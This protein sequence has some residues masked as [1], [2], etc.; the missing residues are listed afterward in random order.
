LD[1]RTL[2]HGPP[3]E[4]NEFD[5][6]VFKLRTYLISTFDPFTPSTYLLYSEARINDFVREAKLLAEVSMKSP[7]IVQVFDF[8]FISSE[9][10]EAPKIPYIVMELMDGTL[11]ESHRKL[12]DSPED[13]AR[14]IITLGKAL[15]AAHVCKSGPLIH[16]DI[17]PNNI[18]YK[19]DESGDLQIKLGDFGLVLSTDLPAPE[20]YN[21]NGVLEYMSPERLMGKPGDVRSDIYSLG[22]VFYVLLTGR[23]PFEAESNSV[24]RIDNIQKGNFPPP[25]TVNPKLNQYLPLQ[26]I[27]QKAM[28]SNPNERYDNAAQLVG[29]LEKALQNAS[30]SSEKRFGHDKDVK[31]LK[32][33][34]PSWMS[35]FIIGTFLFVIVSLS[36]RGYLLI[37]AEFKEG[38]KQTIIA[39]EVNQHK[40]VSSRSPTGLESMMLPK[41]ERPTSMVVAADQQEADIE[42]VETPIIQEAI[43]QNRNS[44]LEK[45]EPKVD[46][47]IV[48][49]KQILE[50]MRGDMADIKTQIPQ[51]TETRPEAMISPVTQENTFQTKRE[52]LRVSSEDVSKPIVDQA[53]KPKLPER[54]VRKEMGSN[55]FIGFALQGLLGGSVP[56]NS[57]PMLLGFLETSNPYSQKS[58]LLSILKIL[59]TETPPPNDI[60]LAWPHII[61]IYEN[62]SPELKDLAKQCLV[63]ID[64]KYELTESQ[65]QQ[66]KK[67][68]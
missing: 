21:L 41:E 53:P 20:D 14:A 66:L 28:A 15:H 25:A 56:D 59:Q 36:R 8:G 17:K 45:E 33:N 4:S 5:P 34:L 60:A 11:A 19:D 43:Q 18:F 2:E 49:M 68:R 30:S 63:V 10:S 6:G 22:I 12:F 39:E 37:Q 64:Q 24:R 44:V 13:V 31:Q 7:H 35:L 52:T 42:V 54:G 1:C 50:Q 29:D 26:R 51:K 16:R 58:G 38:D 55:D 27:C 3:F 62:G 32:Q 47:T 46:P 9:D 61:H 65:F 23:D 40:D 67:L 48:E 57:I